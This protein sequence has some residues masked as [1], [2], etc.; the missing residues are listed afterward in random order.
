MLLRGAFPRWVGCLTPPPTL[1]HREGSAQGFSACN[2]ATNP[3]PPARRGC[4]FLSALMY[5]WLHGSRWLFCMDLGPSRSSD[6]R[7]CRG[8]SV[9]VV[10]VRVQQPSSSGAAR[11]KP[12][13]RKLT[14]VAAGR[15]GCPALSCKKAP[16]FFFF[17]E[18]F[19]FCPFQNRRK[20]SL[21]LCH[22]R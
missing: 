11:S 5:R 7:L 8:S 22:V 19:L 20:P 1:A 17:K 12:G 13:F 6:L 9:M 2:G 3:S 14:L 15:E 21:P 10:P 18:S 16:G 4:R